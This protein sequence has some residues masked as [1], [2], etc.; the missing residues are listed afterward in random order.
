MPEDQQTDLE[1]RHLHAEKLVS[2]FSYKKPDATVTT[3]GFIKLSRGEHVR[4]AVQIVKKNGGENNLHYHT[5]A[6]TFWWVIKGKVRFY[7]PED[8]VIGEFGEGEGIVTPRFSRYW[9]ENCGEEDLELLQ[10]AASPE[11]GLKSGRTDV[12]AQ[13]YEVG[14][15]LHMDATIK[16]G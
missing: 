16:V 3:K 1:S 6:E 13:R 15:G 9:F 2:T 5:H 11:P 14:T 12:T 4:G 10:I 7:G 8:V